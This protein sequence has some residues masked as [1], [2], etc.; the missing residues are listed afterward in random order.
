MVWF[1]DKS[2]KTKLNLVIMA[3]SA[4]TLLLASA[5]LTTYEFVTFRQRMLDDVSTIA[6]LLAANTTAALKFDN[7]ADAEETL[8]SLSFRPTII[9]AAIY[10]PDGSYFVGYTTDSIIA[11]VPAAPQQDGWEIQE[12]RLK[13]VR[14]IV[15]RG[16]RVGTLYIQSTLDPMYSQIRNYLAITVGIL[17]LSLVSA[18]LIG[19]VL[20]RRISRPVLDLAT[21]ARAISERDDYSIRARKE[22]D[23]EIGYLSDALNLMIAK[24]SE[25]SAAIH[26]SNKELRSEIERRERIQKELTTSKQRLDLAQQAGQ[27]GTFD[28]DIVQGTISWNE[29]LEAL[30]GLDAGTFNG[31]YEGWLGYIHPDDVANVQHRIQDALEEKREFLIDFRI[32]YANGAIRWMGGRA[33]VFFEEGRA[34]RMIGINQDITERKLAEERS[35]Y[36]ASV[37]QS[38]DDAIISKNL[39]GIITSWNRGAE[40]I[41]GYRASEIIGKSILTIIPPDRHPEERIILARLRQGE[42]IDHFDTVRLTKDGRQVQ[43]SLTISPIRSTRGEI[44]GASAVA[45]DITERKRQ[46]NE[47]RMLNEDLERRVA[48]RTQQLV[49][50]NKE[51]EAFSYSVSHDLRAPLRAISGYAGILQS[52]FMSK[53]TD[54]GQRY[55]SLISKSAISMGVL[56][57]GLLNFSRLT[58]KEL[59]HATIDMASLVRT[60]IEEQKNLEPEVDHKT[61]TQIDPNLPPCKGDPTMVKQVITNL[62][63]NAFKF[64]GKNPHPRIQF[65]SMKSGSNGMVMYYVKDNGAGFDMQYVDKLFGVFQR[66]HHTDEYEGT[67]IGL[68]FT[69]RI[70]ERHG[71]RIWAEAEVG[72][73]ATFYFT[74]PNA[75]NTDTRHT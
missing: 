48:E 30:Y 70:I 63:S 11:A 55:L 41:F 68:A 3:T 64:T 39:E 65:C 17:V 40:E 53:L 2:I 25:R 73:G 38:S 44:I 42:R 10:R 59:E 23:D 6:D 19:R 43:V 5:C 20:Q 67:G 27:I 13:L 72:S 52:E 74:L 22:S 16:T 51:L 26:E 36:L 62:I 61:T 50:S 9:M 29:E 75:E 69:K 31:T 7:K 71:G 35:L 18:F 34:V 45:K 57:D 8:S 49:A 24:V 60:V 56:V 58:R 32:K 28:W 33:K 1:R 14:P 21:T 37:V 66:L 54:E 4:A 12:G 46:E 15:L 47:I